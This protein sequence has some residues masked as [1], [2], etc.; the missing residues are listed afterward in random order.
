MEGSSDWDNILNN[1]TMDVDGTPVKAPLSCCV[2]R[3]DNTCYRIADDGCFPRLKYVTQQ[4]TTLVGTG[5][6]AVAL[7]QVSLK[8]V[9]NMINQ[10]QTKNFFL[11]ILGAVC[12]FMLASSIRQ[13]K[14]LREAR[15]WQIQQTFVTPPELQQPSY[16][17]VPKGEE[18]IIA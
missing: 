9:L 5:A 17:A 13:T 18:L 10:L 3:G 12:A 14:S 1:T 2:W 4:A 7:V 11:K 6:L 16:E 8:R 15:K